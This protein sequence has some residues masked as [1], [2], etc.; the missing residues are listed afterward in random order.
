M[1]RDLTERRQLER[2][3]LTITDAEQQRI[4]ADLHDGLGQELTG[5][6][7]LAAALR[8]RIRVIRPRESSEADT[9]ARLANEATSKSRALAHGLNPVQIEERGL[10]FALEDLAGQSRRLHGISCEFV[11]RGASP[12][13][14][15]F[16][17]GHLYRIAQEA[18]HNAVRHGGA[19][20]VRVLLISR[21]AGCRL[22]IADNGRGFDPRL[23]SSGTGRGLSL[24]NYRANMLGGSL[25]VSSIPGFG[26]RIC[27]D[28]RQAGSRGMPPAMD[29]AT[30]G[31][32][33]GRP[34]FALRGAGANEGGRPAREQRRP[35]DHSPLPARRR[36]PRP[37]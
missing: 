35:A 18:I 15:G 12:R 11:L 19:R 10:E 36:K 20:R 1:G 25:S 28:W 5:L 9:I 6:A 26:S 30:A 27:C 17:A 16:E 24:M 2:Q 37:R 22:V 29:E 31:L 34:F 13:L 3:L 32:G 33:A 7:C 4:G 8:D 14:G 23:Q 21:N